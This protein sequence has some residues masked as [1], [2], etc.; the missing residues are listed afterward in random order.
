MLEPL[1]PKGDAPR[2]TILIK[3]PV[4][5]WQMHCQ[6]A[7]EFEEEEP[8]NKVI[9]VTDHLPQAIHIRQMQQ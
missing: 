8:E 7:V 5:I 4:Q 6:E 3:V 2:R 1:N 9:R